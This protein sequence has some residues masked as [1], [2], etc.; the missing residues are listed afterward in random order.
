MSC[1]GCSAKVQRSLETS[2]GV[3]AANVNLMT[4]TATVSYYSSATSPE[5]LVEAIRSTG[6]G[7][8]VP[9]PAQS[10]EDLLRTQMRSAPPRQQELK[11]KLLVSAVAAL[12]VM[13]VG[14]RPG[15]PCGERRIALAPAGR[16]PSRR[17]VGRP[18][19]LF[20]RV[21]RVPPPRRRH[22]HADRGRHRCR[23]PLQSGGDAGARLVRREGVSRTC[24]TRRWP[25]SSHSFSSAICSRPAREAVPP[26]RFASL[27][28]LRPPTARVLRNGAET[29]TCP[30]PSFAWAMRCWCAPARRFPPMAS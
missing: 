9:S 8:E 14:M 23:V 6:Y 28:G 17:V 16:H 10:D 27:A 5:R 15:G 20:P 7:A 12:I 26:M 30:L 4:G 18:P 3:S 11:R 22:E 19:F 21:G 13:L 2:P 24:I 29:G 1:A 25:G